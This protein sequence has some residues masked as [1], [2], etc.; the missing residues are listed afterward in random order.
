MKKSPGRVNALSSPKTEE[1]ISDDD[2]PFSW[3]KVLTLQAIDQGV[4]PPRR[5]IVRTVGTSTL[6]KRRKK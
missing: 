3:K 1:Q 6:K 4:P 5:V 2:T